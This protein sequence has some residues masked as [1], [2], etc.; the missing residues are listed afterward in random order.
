VNLET[1]SAVVC[2]W[3]RDI[4]LGLPTS[5]PTGLFA[6]IGGHLPVQMLYGFLPRSNFSTKRT[7]TS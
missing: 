7:L 2:L 6:C 5:V 3:N 4:F 1:V